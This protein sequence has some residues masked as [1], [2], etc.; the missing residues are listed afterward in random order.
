MIRGNKLNPIYGQ[1]GKIIQESGS[2]KIEII[3]TGNIIIKPIQQ[4]K[5]LY[6]SK[7][8]RIIESELQKGKRNYKVELETPNAKEEY[9]I[10]GTSNL[11]TK[12]L[13]DNYKEE[14]G[15]LTK[16]QKKEGGEEEKRRSD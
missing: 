4:L 13:L 12:E 10:S 3:D 15:N 8:L 1:K 2:Y 14:I 16:I 11:L 5:I 7:I 9:W 6:Q